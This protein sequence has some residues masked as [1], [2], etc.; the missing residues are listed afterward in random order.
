MQLSSPG[1]QISI[2]SVFNLAARQQWNFP[3]PAGALYLHL[4]I[5]SVFTLVGCNWFKP[6]QE[7]LV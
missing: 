4:R 7:S 1:G 3:S 5:T 6:A 2:T